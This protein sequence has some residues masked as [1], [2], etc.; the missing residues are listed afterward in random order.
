MGACD[1]TNKAKVNS[2]QFFHVAK[3]INQ[4]NITIQN[5]N[6]LKLEFTIENCIPENRYQVIVQFLNENLEPSW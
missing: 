3:T 2:K 4:N 1:G 6:N 5:N